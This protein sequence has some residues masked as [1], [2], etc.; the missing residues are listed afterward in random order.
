MGGYD[1]N[2]FQTSPLLPL[3]TELNQ[4]VLCDDMPALAGI[5]LGPTGRSVARSYAAALSKLVAKGEF[6]SGFASCFLV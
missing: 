2:G 6:C 4:A 3:A 1:Q 5:Q